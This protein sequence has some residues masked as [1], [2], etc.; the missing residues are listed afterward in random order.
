MKQHESQQQIELF[1]LLAFHRTDP[2]YRVIHASANGG[3]RDAITGARMKKE[4]VLS[5]VWDIF[6]PIP[7]KRHF[8]LYLEMKAGKNKLTPSQVRFRD[9]LILATFDPTAETPKSYA[10]EVCNSA[11]EAYNTIENYL[12]GV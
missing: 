2:R 4:G 6:V 7:T 10:F 3:R 5:G 8:G 9:D 1:R 12:K 11:A